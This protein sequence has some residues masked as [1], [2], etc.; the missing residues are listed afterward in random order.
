MLS[1]LK[2]YKD[3]KYINFNDWTDNKYIQATIDGI[4]WS[5]P[6]DINNSDYAEIKRQV[7]VGELTIEEAEKL[8][9]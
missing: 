3:C 6:I 2:K 4:V 7:D 8:K 9:E 1:S 5:V